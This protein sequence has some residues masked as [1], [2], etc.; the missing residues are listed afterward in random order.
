[1]QV[2]GGAQAADRAACEL[3]GLCREIDPRRHERPPGAEQ[4]RQPAIEIEPA[5]SQRHVEPGGGGQ[6]QGDRAARRR[7]ADLD[8]E[9]VGRR[10]ATGNA[11]TPLGLERRRRSRQQQ[12]QVW[13]ADHDAAAERAVGVEL[14]GQRRAD[15]LHRARA[16]ERSI[17][18]G[19]SVAARLGQPARDAPALAGEKGRSRDGG[20]AGQRVGAQGCVDAGHGERADR[21]PAALDTGIHGGEPVRCA[22]PQRVARDRPGQRRLEPAQHQFARIDPAGEQRSECDAKPQR[23]GP[24]GTVA[25]AA[26]DGHVG[27]R[28][29]GLRQQGQ[30][31]RPI[32]ADGAAEALGGE[33]SDRAAIAV[34]VQCR[35]HRPGTD[36][37]HERQHGEAYPQPAERAHVSRPRGRAGP[38]WRC[39]G[40]LSP[41][42]T[43]PAGRLYREH[44]ARPH[45]GAVRPAQ[46]LPRPVRAL[47]PLP[48]DGAVRPARE[49]EWSDVAA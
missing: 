27:G 46:R 30:R 40:Q 17:E 23:V 33:S 3:R 19:R 6:P 28:Q 4:H 10:Q 35:R 41:A 47:D 20:A 29:D 36:E 45:L 32:D 11:E 18:R 9:V 22:N 49:P 13:P 43:A 44:V 14:G 39:A 37:E 8:G 25:A 16:V 31:D 24:Q 15:A 5:G 34:P 48:P 7:A 12:R 1:M 21:E 38:S 42:V 26:L 2:E